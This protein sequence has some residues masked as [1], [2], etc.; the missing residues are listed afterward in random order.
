VKITVMIMENALTENVYVMKV[1]MENFAVL[2]LRLAKMDVI[3][4]DFV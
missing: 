1:S 2:I 3:K 4:T